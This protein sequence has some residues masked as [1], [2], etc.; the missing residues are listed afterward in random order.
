MYMADRPPGDLTPSLVIPDP[1]L[2]VWERWAGS[3]D[4]HLGTQI[5]TD[6]NTDLG[7][8]STDF[9]KW[10]VRLME[11]SWDCPSSH[12]RTEDLGSCIWLVNPCAFPFSKP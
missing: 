9:L 5:G 3:A 12:T 8:A 2:A 1:Q 11:A 6:A 10:K 7:R 4:I